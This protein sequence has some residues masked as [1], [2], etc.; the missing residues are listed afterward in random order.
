MFKTMF[1]SLAENLYQ[2]CLNHNLSVRTDYK[3]KYY[4]IKFNKRDAK[5]FNKLLQNYIIT[6]M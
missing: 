5:R 6:A 4:I 3:N 2:D 1:V